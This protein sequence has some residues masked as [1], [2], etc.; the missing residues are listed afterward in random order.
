MVSRFVVAVDAG[1]SKT[2]V[3][4][5]GFDGQV[6][7]R[8][9]AGGFVPNRGEEQALERLRDAVA[10]SLDE[11]RIAAAD[12]RCLGLFLANADLPEQEALYGEV[13]RGW[14]L[15]EQ[16]HVANDTFALL[17]SGLSAATGAAVVCGAGINAA[18]VGPDGRLGRLPAL[19]TL[20]GDWGGG[21]GL[22]EAALWAACRGEDGRGAPTA[23]S[24]AI[25]ATFGR[26]SATTI[27]IDLSLG[28]VPRI[29]L[30]DVVPVLFRV[31]REGDKIADTILE[32]QAEEVVTMA[33]VVLGRAGLL[34]LPTEIVLGGG[35]LAAREEPLDSRVLHGL[36]DE[37][38]LA[39]PVFPGGPPITGAVLATLEVVLGALDSGVSARVRSQL[40]A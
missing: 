16:V 21:S 3:A 4:V 28:T 25:A 13:A 38:P 10:R 39:T 2:D 36:A 11:A 8:L 27:A 24:A 17:R 34:H 31:A 29:R 33:R 12:V 19:G 40:D 30:Y 22:A 15:G 5:V 7:H 35:V 9:R 20:T 14:G 6:R 32:R 37:L 1:N 26:D 18:A 23:L